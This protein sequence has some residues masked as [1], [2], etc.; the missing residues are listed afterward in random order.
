MLR[1]KWRGAGIAGVPADAA[2]DHL[3][4]R[5]RRAGRNT[6]ARDINAALA[7]ESEHWAEHRAC[8][9]AARIM[10]FLRGLWIGR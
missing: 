7:W 1:R 6:R 4:L 3:R 8:K 9:I 10:Y 2:D 5:N